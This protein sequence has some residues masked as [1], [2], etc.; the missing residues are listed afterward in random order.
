[1]F[2]EMIS[3][4]NDECGLVPGEP[5]LVGVSGGPD[6]LCLL[7]LLVRAQ[8]D[9]FVAHFN[10]QLRS[11]S[12]DEAEYVKTQAARYGL[13]FLCETQDVK[14][15]AKENGFSIEEAARKLRYHFL[16]SQARKWEVPVIAVAHNADDQVETV[17]MHFLRGAGLSGLKGMTPVTQLPEFD[18][19]IRLIRPLLHTWRKE[20]DSYCR[21]F[22]LDP[23]QDPSNLDQ[24]YFRNHL[25]HALIPEMETYQ[26]GFKQTLLRSIASL[27]GDYKLINE[28]VDHFWKQSILEIGSGYLAFNFEALR[29]ADEALLRNLIR[30]AAVRLNPGIRDVNFDGV[31]RIVR[32]IQNPAEQQGRIDLTD[33]IIVSKE[34]DHFYFA[35]QNAELPVF[36]WPQVRGRIDMLTGSQ[37]QLEGGW[38]FQIVKMEEIPDMDAIK[39]NSDPFQAWLDADRIGQDLFVR[40]RKDGDRFQPLGMSNGSL[41]V[42]DLFIN[43][44][45]PNRARRDWPL[46]CMGNEILWIPGFRSAHPY[47]ITHLTRRILYLKL[48]RSGSH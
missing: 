30:R 9:V 45:L 39:M 23:V 35:N 6:S 40:N 15:F 13:P 28:V 3:F 22:D 27:A 4:L 37:M 1:M 19:K 20:I 44:K 26:T 7:D 16:F 12:D 8:K 24:T 29:S 42:S 18:P 25:R 34:G 38:Y 48:S 2:D 31:Q 5:I 47:R 41:K 33:G 43:E 21:E 46:I 14:V 36:H 10:H 11:E 32:H 17:L